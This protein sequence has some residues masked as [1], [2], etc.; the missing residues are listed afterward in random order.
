MQEDTV[1]KDS[2]QLAK[3]FPGVENAYPLAIESYKTARE[4]FDV[5]EKR[6]QTLIVFVTTVS[7]AIITLTAKQGSNPKASLSLILAFIFYVAAMA[8]AVGSQIYGTCIVPDPKLLREKSL[9]WDDWMFKNNLIDWAGKHFEKNMQ[10]VN[11]R[12]QMILGTLLFGLLSLLLLSLWSTG[13]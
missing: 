6:G 5:M 7:V 9:E 2:K 12:M 4:R 13:S 10:I 1:P 11:T 3:E 8:F